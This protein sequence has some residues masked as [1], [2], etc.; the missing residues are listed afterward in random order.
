MKRLPVLLFLGSFFLILFGLYLV[1][2]A[3][4]TYSGYKFADQF[5]MFNNHLFKAFGGIILM[6]IIAFVPYENYKKY[7]KMILFG[8]MALLIITLFVSTKIKGA[9]RWLDLGF[10]S[11]QTSEI[12]KIALF[13]HLAALLEEKGENIKIFKGGLRYALIWIFGIAVLIF[14][15]PNIS[16]GLIL[17]FISFL[18]LFIGGAKLKHLFAS[19]FIAGSLVAMTAMLFRHSRE[20]ILTFFSSLQDGGAINDQVRQAI[21]GL[22]TGHWIGVGFGHSNQRNL[23]LPEAYGDFIFAILGE[24]TGFVGVVVMLLIYLSLFFIGIVIAKNAKDLFGQYLG[25][26]ISFSFIAS[27]FINASVATGLLPTTGLPLPFLSYGGTSMTILCAS[28]GILI[29]IGLTSAKQKIEQE[30]AVTA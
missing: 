20:R 21:V 16:S 29:N 3:S 5:H 10:V 30:A 2:S 23:F 19:V 12:A 17:L 11:F 28:V 8:V 13:I 24:E 27:A 26:A 15:Q 9:H 14:I 1:M 22:A 25:F 4:S 6:M 18:I 7:S